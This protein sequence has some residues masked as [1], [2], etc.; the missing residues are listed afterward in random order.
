MPPCRYA[1]GGGLAE[2]SYTFVSA[3]PGVLGLKGDAGAVGGVIPAHAG[4]RARS[5]NE[6][7]QN[8]L[9][10]MADCRERG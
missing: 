8:E 7:A 2:R 10:D 1:S 4:T 9:V 6:E 5:L 3:P